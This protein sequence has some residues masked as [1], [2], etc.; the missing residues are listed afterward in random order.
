MKIVAYAVDEG[1]KMLLEERSQDAV[2]I[3]I[4]N[5][6]F[7]KLENGIL[8]V[9][10]LENVRD[11]P[12]LRKMNPNIKI[13][14]S[15]GGWGAGGFS[16]IAMSHTSRRRFIKSVLDILERY[17]FDGLD[18]DWEY[19]GSSIAG[20]TSSPEDKENF[21]NLM[22]ELREALQGKLLS[23]AAGVE[24]LCIENIELAEVQKYVDFVHL[25]TYDMKSSFTKVTGHHTNLYPAE[26]DETKQSVAVAAEKF[27]EREVSKE[28]IFIGAA[29]YGRVWRGVNGD[30][31]GLFQK[32]ETYGSE[33]I[34][35]R[36]L[37][38]KY[39]EKQG[40]KKF[41]D[42]SAK[43]PYLFDGNTFISYDDACSVKEK[44]LF[45]ERMK[46][47]GVIFWEY[48]LDDGELLNTLY[49]TLRI[50]RKEKGR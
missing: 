32:A 4:L 28:K 43:A 49:E 38:S 9:E 16:E 1:V 37:K 2:K 12:R 19:P 29:F 45:A 22:K 50:E 39:I 36:E 21:T 18:V 14:L 5:Y 6:A 17:G 3:D 47:G 20:I 42:D 25:M 8:S 26:G 23:F 15:V 46:L 7:G 34:S 41:W 27:L 33:T 31:N 11:L 30:N 44:M 35:Y 24:D 10:G 48:S 13:V 40:F